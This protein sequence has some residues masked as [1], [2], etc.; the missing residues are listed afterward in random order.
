MIKVQ[1]ILN[2]VNDFDRAAQSYAFKGSQHPDAWEVI[3]E[4]YNSK[5]ARLQNAIKD[6]HREVVV[7]TSQG[8]AAQ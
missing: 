1:T 5:K 7:K 3:T 4:E 2:Y 6:L 8:S